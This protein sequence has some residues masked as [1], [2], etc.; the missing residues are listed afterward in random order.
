MDRILTQLPKTQFSGLEFSNIVEDIY[1]LIKQN[2]NYNSNWSD[3]LN[4]NAGR[5]LVEVFAYIADQLATRIDWNVN[6]NFIG[7]A[8]QRTSIIRLLKLI[9]YNFS[10]PVASQVDVTTTFSIPVGKYTIKPAYSEGSG[11][12]ITKTLT[13]L[14]LKGN[15]R[16]YEAL[17]FDSSSSKFNYKTEIIVD[18]GNEVSPNLKNTITFY[19]GS[20]KI[21]DFVA[22]TPDGQKF[23]IS[24]SPVTR[25]SIRVYLINQNGQDVTETE[26]LQVDNFLD[27]KAQ[28]SGSGSETY[29]IPYILNVLDG[30]KVEIE[31]GSS[32]L[33]ATTDR[34]LPQ[35]STIRVFYRVGGG[36]DGDLVKLSL[37]KTEKVTY[38]GSDLFITY[39]NNSAGVGGEDSETL[40]HAKYY[41]PLKMRTAGKTVSEEDYDIILSSNT[42]TLISKSYGIKNIP[43][44]FYNKY[45][46]FIN[47]LEVWNYIVVKKSGWDSIPTYN[48]KYADFGTFNLENQFNG[49]YSFNSGSFGISTALKKSQ[50]ITYSAN[51]DYN[52]IGGRVFNNFVILKTPADFKNSI[53]TADPNNPGK[54]IANSKMVASITKTKYDKLVHRKIKD[55]PNH[56]LTSDDNDNYFYGDFNNS[57]IPR[58]S[59]EQS[60]RAY[61]ESPIDAT[62]GFDISANR[63]KF[64]LNVDNRGDVL[65]DL[66]RSGTSPL[67]LPL[68]S[69]GS[70]KGA[71]DIINEA[72]AASYGTTKAYQ[73]F[74]ILIPDL[75]AQVE[76]LENADEE[77]WDCK[78]SGIIYKVNTGVT[79]SY[80]AMLT[81][82]NNAIGPMYQAEFI[83]NKVNILCYDIRVTAITAPSVELEESFTQKDFLVAMGATPLRS[84][85]VPAGAYNEI[86][87]IV[88]RGGSKFLKLTSPNSGDNSY[89]VFKMPIPETNDCSLNVLGLNFGADGVSSYTCYGKKTL[90]VIYKDQTEND[91][92]NFIYE[93][94]SIGFTPDDQEFVFLNY[95]TNSR[96]KITLGSYFN[97]NF[98][99]SELMW[100]EL[101]KTIY[102]AVYSVDPDDPTGRREFL[103]VDMSKF[104]L[105]FTANETS[106][107]SLFVIEN[108]YNLIRAA[109]PSKSTVEITPEILNQ[110][111]VN[112]NLKISV[113]S[114]NAKTINLGA[115]PTLQGIVDA[116]NDAFDE[117]SEKTPADLA[118]PSKKFAMLN[119]ITDVITLTSFNK[120]S[121]N[122]TIYSGGIGDCSN[123]LFSGLLPNE[124]I[125]KSSGDYYIEYDSINKVTNMY[126]IDSSNNI[127]DLDFYIHFIVDNRWTPL[128]PNIPKKHTDEDDFINFM[129]PYKIAGVENVFKRPIFKTF[130]ITATIYVSNA[131]PLSQIR[132]SVSLALKKQFSLANANFNKSIR[133]SEII[134]IILSIPGVRYTEIEYFGFNALDS[135]SNLLNTLPGDFDTLLVLSDDV[136]DAGGNQQHGC[137]FTYNTI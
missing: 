92:A 82:L 50:T 101:P 115:Y 30:D 73:D 62:S 135:S 103:D 129:K 126:M 71:V 116:L 124:T 108:E 130:D 47:P 76:T 54:Y 57:G 122:I 14:D 75:T 96:N 31:F 58:L 6:E 48:Y 5:M 3:F 136:F 99:E 2:P 104:E 90:T 88:D 80:N 86:A 23:I 111:R 83:Q 39:A 106:A 43:S 137:A 79:Q 55:I 59:M 41:G 18:T 45:G 87:S 26:L 100:R 52:N 10:L 134:A 32:S 85:P 29:S 51:Y 13:A 16:S 132:N 34:R 113:N 119:N 49:K 70:I 36:V 1:N 42:K 67:V 127:P 84:N 21:E 125:I 110:L 105:R 69:T 65:I 74:G 89:L 131:F 93:N 114:N 35:G 46:V 107:N 63:N 128:D 15:S 118:N 66:S 40:D 37:Q 25:N 133:K 72:I 27:P 53:Y 44:T 22:N 120:A 78:I 12:F 28:L 81:A 112:G 8:T 33:L 68:A 61:Y 4:S 121:G 7:T 11:K 109:N 98:D 102:N 91:F 9:G 24:G 60:I 95:I 94:G 20:T 56:L 77:L 19:E 38:L 64:V 117:E 17:E 123:I 97:E